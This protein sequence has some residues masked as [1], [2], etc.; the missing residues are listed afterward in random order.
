MAGSR[1]LLVDDDPVI[2]FGIG[3]FLQSKEMEVYEADSVRK[4]RDHI[5]LR[6]P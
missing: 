2:R 5:S 3:S 1:I 4:A 6:L